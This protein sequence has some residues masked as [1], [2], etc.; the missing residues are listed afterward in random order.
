MI[1]IS[2]RKI[3]ILVFGEGLPQEIC[4]ILEIKNI[5]LLNIGDINLHLVMG[6]MTLKIFIRVE[7]FA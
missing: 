2:S 5:S 7:C 3:E 4:A 1:I 6:A